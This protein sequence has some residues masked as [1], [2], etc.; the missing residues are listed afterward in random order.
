MAPLC[1]NRETEIHHHDPGQWRKIAVISKMMVKE[2]EIL[3]SGKL[4]LDSLPSV[5]VMDS[6]SPILDHGMLS[7]NI[8]WN[9]IEAFNFHG[10]SIY[11]LRKSFICNY[12]G[13]IWMFTKMNNSFCFIVFRVWFWMLFANLLDNSLTLKLC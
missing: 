8:I 1:L 6:I 5:L 9:R 11:A 13:C 4:D 10:M 3:D 2:V 7:F 12:W